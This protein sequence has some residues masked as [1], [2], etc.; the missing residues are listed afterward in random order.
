MKGLNI[1]AG[2]KVQNIGEGGAKVEEGTSQSNTPP[3]PLGCKNLEPAHPS[4]HLRFQIFDT[5]LTLQ[6]H[7]LHSRHILCFKSVEY[8][9][10]A[11]ENFGL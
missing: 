2:G 9:D 3:P 11:R 6:S 5:V 8:M 4:P 7:F 10:S 1:G